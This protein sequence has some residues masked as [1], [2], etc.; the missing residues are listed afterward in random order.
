MLISIAQRRMGRLYSIPCFR[1]VRIEALDYSANTIVDRRV[2]QTAITAIVRSRVALSE[3][4]KQ[5]AS[6]TW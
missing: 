6:E 1:I 2:Q 4:N 3:W 5:D